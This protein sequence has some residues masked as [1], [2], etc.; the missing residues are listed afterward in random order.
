MCFFCNF[1]LVFGINQS[2]TLIH[3]FIP[4]YRTNFRRSGRSGQ[5]LFVQRRW[6]RNSIFDLCI[7]RGER[8]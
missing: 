8:P 2:D 1:A 3:V 6:F 5:R 7:S 4:L